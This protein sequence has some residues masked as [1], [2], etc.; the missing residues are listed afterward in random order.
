MDEERMLPQYYLIKRDIIDK[1][2]TGVYEFNQKIESENV[3]SAKYG[4][5]RPTVR[6]ALDELVFLGYLSRKQGKG[7]FVDRP[8]INKNLNQYTPFSEDVAAIGKKMLL[9][10]LEKKKITADPEISIKLSI[11]EGS[12]VL[13]VVSIRIADNLPKLYRISY[14]PYY[15]VPDLGKYIVDDLP[16]FDALNKALPDGSYIAT[17]KQTFRVELSSDSISG[18]LGVPDGTPLILWKGVSFLND[19]TPIEYSIALHDSTKF[20]FTIE[21]HRSI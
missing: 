16:I 11:P 19:G 21:Q 15:R 1:I 9:K 3:L 7:T 13:K 5:S 18:Y 17:S 6:K 12:P 4:V 20:V 2:Q 14:Y 8:V 10:V